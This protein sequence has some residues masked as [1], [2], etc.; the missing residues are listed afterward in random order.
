M[1]LI[2]FILYFEN[3]LLINSE[4]INL[5]WNILVIVIRYGYPPV[6]LYHD[7]KMKANEGFKFL[8]A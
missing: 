3:V 1:R 7:A 8:P 6:I 4:T 2:C 5:L